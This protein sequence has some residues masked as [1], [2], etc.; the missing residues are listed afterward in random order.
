MKTLI[1]ILLIALSLNAYSQEPTLQDATGFLKEKIESMCTQSTS[2]FSVHVNECVL[3]IY[4][5]I[6]ADTVNY[7]HLD[8]SEIVDTVYYVEKEKFGKTRVIFKGPGCY[9]ISYFSLTGDKEEVKTMNQVVLPF[10]TKGIDRIPFI[11]R[12]EKAALHA[13]KLCKPKL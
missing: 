7:Y 1:T 5:Y 3:D 2:V 10:K 6:D 13:K 8:L 9:M 11:E 4:E 12:I